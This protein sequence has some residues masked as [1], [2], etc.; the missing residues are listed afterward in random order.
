MRCYGYI[1]DTDSETP[2]ELEEVT[3]QAGPD[4]LRDLARFLLY[5]ADQ[6]ELHGEKF[7]HELADTRTQ[8]LCRIRSLG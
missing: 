5:A 8:V 1:K 2:S 6:M 3:M 7:G 4:T